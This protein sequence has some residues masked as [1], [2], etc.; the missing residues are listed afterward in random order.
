MFAQASL[1][2]TL[3][4]LNTGL[5]NI[6]SS[7]LSQDQEPTRL[8]CRSLTQLSEQ[9][10]TETLD[11]L[12]QLYRRLSDSPLPRDAGASTR[13]SP[14]D[15][16]KFPADSSLERTRSSRDQTE[17]GTRRSNREG[18]KPGVRRKNLAAVRIV[19]SSQRDA[20][21]LDLVR[22]AWVRPKKAPLGSPHDPSSKT[23]KYSLGPTITSR[24]PDASP[25]SF[26]TLS[27]INTAESA[28]SPTI[29]P[30]TPT[31]DPVATCVEVNP[32]SSWEQETNPQTSTS[33]MLMWRLSKLTTSGYSFASDST[34]LGEI[35]V[36]SWNLPD[37]LKTKQPMMVTSST[38]DL[39]DSVQPT[40][41]SRFLRLFKKSPAE[42]AAVV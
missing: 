36:R 19:M 23:S 15:S 30:S 16:G 37:E 28:S 6:I 25:A 7:F 41:R 10:R 13:R 38:F 14:S 24:P 33:D 2:T 31:I 5:V 8:D 29:S 1:A 9:S 26:H 17:A 18:K 22:G 34:K 42:Q 39:V 20:A 11:A 3:L 35:P 21:S 12:E 27:P 40:V 4:K 32:L